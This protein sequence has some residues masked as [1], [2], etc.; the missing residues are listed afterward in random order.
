[1]SAE[2][3]RNRRADTRLRQRRG[4]RLRNLLR[5]MLLIV[6]PTLFLGITWMGVSRVNWDELL[7]LRTWTL[8]GLH[9]ADE[10]QA[11]QLTNTL[12]G[13]PL[14]EID[15]Q[16]L[17]A[18]LERDPW[19]AESQ[20]LRHWPNGLGVRVEEERAL[21]FWLAA[22][23]VWCLSASGSCL[24]WPTGPDALELPVLESCS[25]EYANLE[26]ALEDAARALS[27]MQTHFPSLFSSLETIAWSEEPQLQ[28]KNS[29]KTLVMRR[30]AWWHCLSK[31]ELLR[32]Q[33][34][35]LLEKS[36]TLDLRFTN[37]IIHRRQNV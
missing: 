7:N 4:R 14:R 12:M 27:E 11:R 26:L 25:L 15:L 18:A 32:Q 19:I 30:D 9:H 1:M 5:S 10:S 22:P 31:L 28:F 34:P 8:S 16:E 35:D 36:G 33:E 13:L 37:Q 2:S 6:A 17:E 21:A 24:P 20:A 29:S 23:G 3:S